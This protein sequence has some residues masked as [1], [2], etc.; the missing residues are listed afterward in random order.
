MS[1]ILIVGNSPAAISAIEHI[2]RTE[3]SSAITLFCPEQVL[4]YDRCF[5][6]SLVAKNIK[7]S[8]V[9]VGHEKF[10]Q[11]H[12]VNVMLNES[13]TRIS[14]K[15]KQITTANKTHVPFDKLLLTDLPAVQLPAVKGH[16]KKGIFNACRLSEVKDLVKQLPFID[17]IIVPV[18]NFAGFDMACAL[19]RMG[20]EVAVAAPA[21]VLGGIF[22]D[23]TSALLKQ[24]VEARGVR[25]FIDSVEELLGDAAVKAARL[26]SG[27]VI[28]AQAIVFDDVRPDVRL[29]E[30][31]GLT[32]NGRIAVGE[33]FNTAAPDVFACDAALGAFDLLPQESAR[34]GICAAA[35]MLELGSMVYEPPTLLREF[36]AKICD[37]FCGGS[38]R[39]QEGGREHMKFDG[40]R[41]IYKKIFVLNDG[42]VGAV[43]LNA[44]EDKDKV[45]QALAQKMPF[46]DGLLLIP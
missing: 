44:L 27:K 31:S 1:N 2:R 6:P 13:L 39:L 41:N 33:F 43:W 18:A 40:P 25:V 3:V 11:E 38:V 26:K 21:G 35:N 23:D 4:P 14:A 5:L 28:A 30:D 10:F 32:D 8:Q 45:Q 29:L 20:K 34:Q 19:S 46:N 7:E 12:K 15:R 36:G 16:H 22:D 37:G 9:Y 42:L 24:M 17:N